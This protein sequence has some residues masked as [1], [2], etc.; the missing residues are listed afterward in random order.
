M[1]S[2]IGRDFPSIPWALSKQRRNL[3]VAH[4]LARIG[5]MGRTVRKRTRRALG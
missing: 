4:D 5:D 3:R 2:W 1:R